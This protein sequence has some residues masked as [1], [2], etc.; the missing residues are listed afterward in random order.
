MKNP[1]A[2][3]FYCALVALLVLSTGVFFGNLSVGG[4]DKAFSFISSFSSLVQA[5]AAIVVGGIAFHGLS[6]WRNQII[7]GKALG[8][9]W[10]AQVA[11]R[12]I[13]AACNV[14]F[15]R[16]NVFDRNRMT[17]EEIKVEIAGTA[18]GDAFDQF[19]Y[20]CILLD[21]V[22]VKR[23]SDWQDHASRLE[24][25]IH[26]LAI[27]ISKPLPQ[28]KWTLADIGKRSDAEVD[29]HLSEADGYVERMSTLLDSLAEKYTV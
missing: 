1:Y 27:E 3:G 25:S 17:K 11:L 13:E 24:N 26:N 5:I 16:I 18:L 28:S 6:A 14:Y 8:V 12:Q 20:Q 15:E 22:V 19:K 9:I 23:S 2:V 29:K 7:Y 10:D 21:K 4:A